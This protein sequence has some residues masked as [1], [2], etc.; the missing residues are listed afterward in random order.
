[1]IWQRPGN[2]QILVLYHEYTLNYIFGRRK[3]CLSLVYNESEHQSPWRW[4]W[5]RARMCVCT[6]DVGEN[7][8][9]SPGAS[10]L[11]GMTSYLVL[12]ETAETLACL[13]PLATLGGA[14]A[15]GLLLG[16]LSAQQNNA[17]KAERKERITLRVLSDPRRR[18]P[19]EHQY[20]Q[21]WCSG[22]FHPTAAPL[23]LE[24]LNFPQGQ[25]WA[26][27]LGGM[28]YSFGSPSVRCLNKS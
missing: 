13:F 3:W 28:V 27:Q 12:W 22:A 17:D 2:S 18:F 11:S 15:P 9:A 10:A 16:R 19:F 21:G 23:D 1:M 26:Q 14:P 4:A 7:T 5:E 25:S 20:P 24:K 6:H 8:G